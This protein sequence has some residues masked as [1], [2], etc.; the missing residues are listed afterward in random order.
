MASPPGARSEARHYRTLAGYRPQPGEV[1]RYGAARPSLRHILVAVARLQDP[2][3]H[4]AGGDPRIG[5][6]LAEHGTR[7]DHGLNQLNLSN[8][9]M[10][11]HWLSLSLSN[12]R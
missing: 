10:L 3:S 12:F 5:R 4:A 2:D 8:E 1:R 6:I 11:S 9:V 7:R